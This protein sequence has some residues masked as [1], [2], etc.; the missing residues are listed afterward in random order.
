MNF[1]QELVCFE[2]E[3]YKVNVR[4]GYLNKTA[5]QEIL[6]FLSKSMITENI[7]EPLNSGGRTYF[8]LLTDGSSSA[9][10]M[11]KKELYVIKIRSNV[12]LT[13]LLLSSQMMLVQ[14]AL[15]P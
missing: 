1:Y 6:L 13:F 5:V 3:V 4:T 12:D 11:D 8:S 15:K 9:K 2:K 10:T 7:M 14:K